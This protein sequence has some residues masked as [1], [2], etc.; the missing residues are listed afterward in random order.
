MASP[1]RSIRVQ[2]L[3]TL[4][5]GVL[6]LTA[7]A[8]V[9]L[10]AFVEES[11]EHGL[12]AALAAKAEAI[13]GAVRVGDDGQPHL[14]AS[15]L[16]SLAAGG[17]RE[18]P[19]SFQVWRADGRTLAR[20]APG[21]APLPPPPARRRRPFAD[22]VLADGTPARV[23]R[24]TFFARPDTAGS[25]RPTARSAAAVR[26]GEQ[27]TLIVAHDRRAEDRPLAVL[28]AGLGVTA[29]AMALGLVV[30]VTWGVRRGLRPV[31]EVSALADRIGPESL[32]VRFPGSDRLP[33]ELVPVGV[34]LNDLLDRLSAAF[35][36]ERRFSA[37]VAHELRTPLAELRSACDVA[38]RWPDDA[39][40]TTAALVEA[41]DVAVHMSGMV[42]TLLSLARRQSGAEPLAQAVPV[43]LA[44]AVTAA[45]PG[46]A[47]AAAGRGLAIE[48]DLDD[49]GV[50]LADPGLLGAVLR[51]LLE[52]AVAHATAGG[53]IRVY[54]TRSAD[55]GWSLHV[56]NTCGGLSASDLPRI[57]EP[58]WRGN[59]AR[60]S[61]GGQVGLGLT[62]VQAYCTAMSVPIEPTLVRPDQ[63]MLTLTF[64][65]ASQG[66][67][68]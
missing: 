58:F 43:H 42:A 23:T 52:N 16:T 68:G 39:A 53:R 37:A 6:L 57:F 31:G 62:L 38:L 49:A 28:L 12:D 35:A 63:L 18:G 61:G 20:S 46:P 19:F 44:A 48:Q 24:V 59:A 55:G 40:T 7:A 64:P 36:R 56:V 50:A 29:A 60:T 2:L 8:G 33:H 10:Y 67:L 17:R 26:P 66:T 25:D 11:L 3:S 41:R 47:A 51:N 15:D 54:T 27:L 22:A 34:K 4:I 45:W 9:G 30:I 14:P 1:M 13:A 32:D 5:P 21:S 65:P